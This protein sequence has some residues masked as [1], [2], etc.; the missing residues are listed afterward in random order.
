MGSNSE[1]F[2]RDPK[3]MDRV[4]KCV[5]GSDNEPVSELQEALSIKGHLWAQSSWRV[6][7]SN[8]DELLVDIVF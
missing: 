7:P 5:L 2:E 3:S 6:N 1:L 8:L 4:T